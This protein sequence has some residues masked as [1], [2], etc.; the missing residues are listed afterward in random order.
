M[1]LAIVD[2]I[3]DKQLTLN[4][5]SLALGVITVISCAVEALCRALAPEDANETLP[6]RTLWTTVL[7]VK[8]FSERGGGG[9]GGTYRD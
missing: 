8:G 3:S 4:D 2:S 9:K 5:K 7:F 1:S 6:T